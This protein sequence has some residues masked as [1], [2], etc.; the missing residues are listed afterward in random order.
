M[1]EQQLLE[2]DI[3]HAPRAYRHEE[4]KQYHF[5]CERKSGISDS[6]SMSYEQNTEQVDLDKYPDA[7]ALYDTCLKF[8]SEVE[9]L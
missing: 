4:I 8:F 3:Y 5:A 6:S 7:R 1:P 9:N 2:D